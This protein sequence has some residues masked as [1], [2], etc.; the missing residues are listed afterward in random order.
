MHV[1]IESGRHQIDIQTQYYVPLQDSIFPTLTLTRE[2]QMRAF[3]LLIVLI[4]TAGPL[5]ADD[6]DL[7]ELFNYYEYSSDLASSGQPTREQLPAIAEAGIS[8]VINLAPL[9][10]PGAYADEGKRFEELGID[11]I[12]IP[13][14]WEQPPLAD[15]K[16]FLVAMDQFSGKRILVH[17]MANARASLFVYLWRALEA[18]DN[19]DDAYKTMVTIWGNNEDFELHNFEQWVAFIEEARTEFIHRLPP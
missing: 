5:K 6:I 18:G 11:Y 12:H 13:V 2:R 8:A 10:S 9:T 1:K 3:I 15:L 4:A 16:T 17:C 19:D 7:F 14:N